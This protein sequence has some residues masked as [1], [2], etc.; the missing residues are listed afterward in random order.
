M[1][2]FNDVV[3]EKQVELVSDML[4]MLNETPTI[5]LSTTHYVKNWLHIDEGFAFTSLEQAT[6]EKTL[7][8]Q[9]RWFYEQLIFATHWVLANK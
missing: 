2:V 7:T 4:D 6:Q 9:I 3:D 5:E 8:R 1:T